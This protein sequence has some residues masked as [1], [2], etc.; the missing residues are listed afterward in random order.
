MDDVVVVQCCKHAPG[1]Q[2][3]ARLLMCVKPGEQEVVH[4]SER[5]CTLAGAYTTAATD[6]RKMGLVN[7]SPSRSALSLYAAMPDA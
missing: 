2:F 5:R 1:S 7:C 6:D 4:A 3:A